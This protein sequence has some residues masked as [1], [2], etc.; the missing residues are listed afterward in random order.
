V[1]NLELEGKGRRINWRSNEREDVSLRP[2]KGKSQNK[3]RAGFG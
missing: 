3:N 2:K 1:F